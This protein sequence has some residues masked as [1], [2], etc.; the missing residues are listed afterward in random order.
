MYTWD[1]LGQSYYSQ[2]KLGGVAGENLKIAER[3]KIRK[4]YHL[5]LAEV[6]NNSF[7]TLGKSRPKVAAATKSISPHKVAKI[8]TSTGKFYR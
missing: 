7:Q 5:D 6:E 4:W 8:T 2:L 3:T 1:I